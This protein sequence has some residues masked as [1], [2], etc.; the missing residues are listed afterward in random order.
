LKPKENAQ[1]FHSDLQNSG[2][3]ILENTGHTL[4]GEQPEESLAIVTEFLS[5]S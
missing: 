1:R 5:K 2:L 4:M 3:I